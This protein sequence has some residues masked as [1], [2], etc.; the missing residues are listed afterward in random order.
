MKKHEFDKYRLDQQNK[1]IIFSLGLVVALVLAL[2]NSAYA[3][4]AFALLAGLI[5]GNAFQP[6]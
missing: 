1:L 2:F 6:K 4:E 5:T 3:G